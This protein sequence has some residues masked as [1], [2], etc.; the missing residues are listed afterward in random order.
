MSSQSEE[1]I[2]DEVMIQYLLSELPDAETERLDEL[3]IADDEF[4]GRLRA[5]EYDLI[6]S[7]VRGE[8]S[9]EHLKKLRSANKAEKVAFSEALLR[10]EQGIAAQ[11]VQRPSRRRVWFAI[12]MAAAFVLLI[13]GAY[14]V[15]RREQ[16][17]KEAKASVHMSARPIGPSPRLQALAFVLMPANRA[18]QALPTLRLPAGTDE[19]TFRLQLEL[20]EFPLYQAVLTDLASGQIAW[21][22]GPVPSIT[23]GKDR[24]V[25]VRLPARVLGSG[26]FAFDLSGIKSTQLPELIGSYPFKVVTTLNQSLK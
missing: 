10:R 4:A 6:D 9:S 15:P 8:I 22:G 18:S 7:S 21:R 14:L 19:V 11:E 3:S 25:L 13:V 12:A 1:P 16:K 24:E 17:Q 2:S 23:N 20:D 26:D 5:L